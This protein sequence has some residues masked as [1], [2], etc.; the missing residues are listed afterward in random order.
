VESIAERPLSREVESS[1]SVASALQSEASHLLST[2]P[3]QVSEAKPAQDSLPT[4]FDGGISRHAQ[5][6]I[7]DYKDRLSRRLEE[8]LRSRTGQPGGSDGSPG[9]SHS[10]PAESNETKNLENRLTKDIAA[11][12]DTERQ[13][14]VAN[15]ET[16]LERASKQGLDERAEVDGTLRVCDRL[17]KPGENELFLDGQFGKAQGEH[18]RTILAEQIMAEAAYPSRTDQGLFGTCPVASLETRTWFDRPAVAASLIADQALNGQ[19][20]SSD[21]HLVKLP[22]L[23]FVADKYSDLATPPD[24]MRSY[25]GQLFQATALSDVFSRQSIPQFYVTGGIVVNSHGRDDGV[26]Y[27]GDADGKK[28]GEYMGLDDVP[29]SQEL[30][31]LNGPNTE[32]LCSDPS[33]AGTDANVVIFNNKEELKARLKE[34]EESGKMPVIITVASNDPFFGAADPAAGHALDHDICIDKYDPETGALVIDNQ[35]G[36]KFDWGTKSVL[37]APSDLN[38]VTNIDDFFPATQGQVGRD[39]SLRL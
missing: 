21:G 38:P 12:S 33:E 24:G 22:R 3:Q 23:D 2:N 1:A 18:L 34:A 27:L 15:M 14:F 30:R 37:G 10:R 28:T 19:W 39:N 36:A 16:F 31:R 26:E 9:G 35:W 20:V 6:Y 25:A 29:N 13:Q 17:L 32:L 5:V 8:V 11:L 7:D 4:R